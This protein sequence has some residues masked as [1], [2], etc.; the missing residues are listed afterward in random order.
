MTFLS[1]MNDVNVP[2]K[3]VINKKLEKK[4]YLLFVSLTKRA[5]SGA[6]SGTLSQ[7]FG[8]GSIPKCHG[9]GTVSQRLGAGSV[10][11]CH[12][13]GTLR[14]VIVVRCCVQVWWCPCTW[15]RPWWRSP[16]PSSSATVSRSTSR[17]VQLIIYYCFRIDV[18]WPSTYRW[19]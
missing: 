17:Q 13:S 14:I 2:S 5:G 15:R 6:E 18:P 19:K 16:T 4:N 8:A 10:P 3:R 12:G 9:S 1:L 7:R 11:K